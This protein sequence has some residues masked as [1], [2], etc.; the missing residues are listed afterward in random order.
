MSRG[1]RILVTDGLA[2]EGMAA[3]RAEAEVIEAEGLEMLRTV[4]ALIVRSRTR[5][6]A[7]QIAGASPPLVVIGRA[8]VGV[9]NIDLN[10]A[11]RAGV[12]VVNAPQAATDAVA[13]HALA[14]MFSLARRIPQADASMKKGEWLKAGWQ[15]SELAGKTLG[16]V[17]YG[18]IG[19]ALGARAGALGMHVVAHDPL[20]P[21]DAIRDGGA[22]PRPLDAL[23]A[24]ADY[25]SLHVP[26][27]EATRG[28]IAGAAFSRM[29][30]GARLICT[31]RGAVVD[32]GA[33]RDA[34]EGGRLAGA[35]LDVFADEPPG[36]SPLV[37]H[38]AVVATPH[39]GAQTAEAQ[40]RA[41]VDIAFEV[42][43]ALRGLPLRW[44]VA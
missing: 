10:A 20:I 28:M 5:V 32:E 31:A 18:R 21:E 26:L 24:E 2:P 42:L 12:V 15:G 25:I 1:W 23:L 34:L 13:E 16:L 19:R 36:I 7:S 37:A 9:D 6:N 44:R 17:G 35:A 4:H 43:A 11:R 39:I 29:K 33:L 3:L 30:T 22:E 8:G 38:P 14:L 40:R 41:A 27:N